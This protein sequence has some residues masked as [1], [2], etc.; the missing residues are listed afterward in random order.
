MPFLFLVCKTKERRQFTKN[1]EKDDA[2][3]KSEQFSFIIDDVERQKVLFVKRSEKLKET[4]ETLLKGYDAK[5]VWPDKGSVINVTGKIPKRSMPVDS[6]MFE[7]WKYNVNKTIIQFFEQ[8]DLKEHVFLPSWFEHVLRQ[9]QEINVE[10]P[11]S[12][13]IHVDKLGNSI[14]VV[15]YKENVQSLSAVIKELSIRKPGCQRNWET[16]Y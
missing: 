9:L 7:A 3:R 5:V 6:R 10:N 4:L 1:P 11:D 2:Y 15:G 12:V 14:K 16:L 8:L 13:E